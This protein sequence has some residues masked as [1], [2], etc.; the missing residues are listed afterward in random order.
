MYFKC[1]IVMVILCVISFAAASTN[2]TPRVLS[3]NPPA[4]ANDVDP[5][6]DKITVTF[7]TQMMDQSWSWTGGGDTYPQTTGKPFYDE[8]KT[9]CTMP[10]K[11][12]HG[13]VYWV[14]I[15]SPSHKNFQTAGHEPA[16]RYVILFATKT[17]DGKSTP[18]S[19]DMLSKAKAINGTVAVPLPKVVSTFPKTFANDVDPNL[20][21]IT[22]LFNTK[23]MDQSWSWTGGGDTY[24]QTTGKPFYDEAKTTCTM[25]V[26]LEP[27]KVYWVGINSP[28]HKNFQTEGRAPAKRY[29]I[30]FATQSA[31]GKPT[32][33]P[34]D[35]RTQAEAITGIATP[36]EIDFI[37]TRTLCNRYSGKRCV[38]Q[39]RQKIA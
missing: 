28:S 24:P 6:I 35:L 2:P 16:K 1:V 38:Y 7:N 15:N 8:T 13:K 30:L 3:T 21:K 23:M 25:P 32:P 37:C 39:H 31:E 26:K 5:S 19:A 29:V 18:I 9:T 27:G 20:N 10:V 34:D 12:E 36:C 4:F 11:L 17:S 33:I 22:V 14:G